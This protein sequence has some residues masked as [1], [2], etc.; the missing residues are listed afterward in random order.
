MS[1]DG[2]LHSDSWREQSFLQRPASNGRRGTTF[3]THQLSPRATGLFLSH[4]CILPS[5]PTQPSPE[6]LRYYPMIQ[7]SPANNGENSSNLIS[8]KKYIHAK[9][10]VGMVGSKCRNDLEVSSFNCSIIMDKY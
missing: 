10:E 6:Y 2:D 9:T 8:F 4:H 7:T 1:V 5:P 3:T